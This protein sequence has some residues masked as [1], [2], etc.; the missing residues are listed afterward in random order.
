[1]GSVVTGTYKFVQVSTGAVSTTVISREVYQVLGMET[2]PLR[3]EDRLDGA[4][5]FLSWKERVTLALKE[6]DLWE[7]VDKVV[8][9]PTDPDSFGS[10]QEEGDQSREGHLGFSEGSSNSSLI[11]EE[12]NQ[13][14]V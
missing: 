8:V 12:D 3:V 6:Y 14:D 2:T 10:S 9:P 11:Q 5:N 4:S 1:M 13:R 7:L